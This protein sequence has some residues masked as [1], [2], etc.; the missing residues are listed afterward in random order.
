MKHKSKIVI[1]TYYPFPC[2]EPVLENVFAKEIGREYDIIWLFQG[3]VSNGI[4][5]R[6]NNSEVLLIRAIQG[7]H[8]LS[9][10][11]NKALSDKC[12]DIDNPF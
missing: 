4:R 11:V 12:Q 7:N 3:N 6:W 1:I 2:N 10:I 5:C 8:L 9:V